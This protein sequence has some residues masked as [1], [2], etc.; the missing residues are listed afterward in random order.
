[1]KTIT[2]LL[3]TVITV[4]YGTAS[5]S[6][7]C[8]FYMPLVENT[9][10]VYMSYDANGDLQGSQEMQITKVISRHDF[11]EASINS[12]QY[13]KNN[14]LMYQGE[15]GVKCIEDELV[16]DVESILD[17][18]MMDGFNGMEVRME[19]RDIVMPANISEGQLLPDARADIKV[20]SG[21]MTVTELNFTLK[22]R[23]VGAKE[24]VNVPAGT[25]DAYKVT[26]NSVIE[27]K[28]MGMSSKMVFTYIEYHATDVGMIRSETYDKDGKKM[29]YT[30]LS[31]IL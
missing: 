8:N 19:T 27:S 26:Y 12:K 15:F 3:A 2:K 29:G 4:I 6:Q 30:V 16:I 24:K 25:F 31:K 11:I 20:I 28:A 18:S 1:M 9:G 7:Q 22:D 13:D 21:G 23:K 17:P 14:R 10:A 5:Y